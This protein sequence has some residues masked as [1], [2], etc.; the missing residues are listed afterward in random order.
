[1][2]LLFTIGVVVGCFIG[3][4]AAVVLLRLAIQYAVMRGLGW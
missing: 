4:F 3:G 1:M 2:E